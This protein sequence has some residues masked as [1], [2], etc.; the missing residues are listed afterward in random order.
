MTEEEIILNNLPLIYQCIKQLNLYWRTEDEWQDYYGSGLIGLII[1]AKTYDE[2]KGCTLSTYL[3]P[4]IRNKIKQHLIGKTRVK[5]G[6]GV[7]KPISIDL[8]VGDEGSLISDFI[9]D[10]RVNI[11][12]EVERKILLE[13]IIDILNNMKNEKDALVTKMHYGL[14]GYPEM[15]YRE[16]AERYGVSTTMI[17][18]R[19]ERAIKNIKKEIN[20][21]K[22]K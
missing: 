6:C 1:G 5:R 21:W 17:M 11:E 3:M 18:L 8:E 19:V 2:S 10:D 12:K 14:D 7:V 13:T 22:I 15:T 9:V 16:I 20:E 4:C